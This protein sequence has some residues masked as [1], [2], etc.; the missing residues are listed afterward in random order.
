VALHKKISKSQNGHSNGSSSKKRPYS[1]IS[2]TKTETSRNQSSKSK[3]KALDVG[4]CDEHPDANHTNDTCRTQK[5]RLERA[6]TAQNNPDMFPVT[7][8]VVHNP[9]S[10]CGKP[11]YKGHPCT[12]NTARRGPSSSSSSS[13]RHSHRP[14]Q[15]AEQRRFAAAVMLSDSAPALASSDTSAQR[16]PTRPPVA[17][18]NHRRNRRNTGA[19]PAAQSMPDD[20]AMD[21]DDM[22]ASADMDPDSAAA[23]AK[24]AQR[25][26][27][28]N[29]FSVP[30][31]NKS[32]CIIIPIVLQ[33][34]RTYAMI[35]T[36]ANFS[37]CTPEF[38]AAVA[39]TA[40]TTS[41]TSGQIQLGHTTAVHN[42]IG[43]VNLQL[44]YNKT[45]INHTFEV[46]DIFT[47]INNKNI[48]CCI[49]MDLFHHLNLGLTGL[50]VTH[51]DLNSENTPFPP[52]P[53]DPE[54]E[55]DKVNNSPFGID[56][57][58]TQMMQVLN[59]LFK[60][61]ANIDIPNTYCNLPGAIVSLQ[62]KPGCVAYRKPYPLP[63]AFKDAVAA[64]ILTWLKEN[65][66]EVSTSH[67]GF[68]SNLLVVSKKDT[69]SGVY[70]F[71][72]PR[73]VVDLRNLNS[74]LEVT[75]TQS[76]PLISEIHNKIGNAVVHSVI[77]IKSCF[78]TFLV[79]KD[80]R[81]KLSFT[82]PYTN[83]QYQFVKVPFGINFMGNLV[84]RVLQQLF[85][86][87]PSVTVYVD[88][89]SISTVGD[90]ATHTDC[91]A[92]V[93]RRLT[94][95]NLVISAEKVVLAQTTISILGWVISDGALIPDYRKV[96]TASAFKVPTTATQLNSFLGYMN[97]F[98]GSIPLF[99]HISAPL[100]KLR[101]VSNL[102]ECWTDLHTRAFDKL[103]NALVSAPLIFP[104]D[105]HYPLVVATDASNT[106]ISGVLYFVK[107]NRMHIVALASR[108]LSSTE[109]AYSTTRREILAIVYCFQRF[110][111][112]LVNRHF[113]LHTD[114]RSLIYLHSQEVPNHL[115][116]T[117]Y[118]TLFS[119]DYT[120]VH[121]P[122]HL[123]YIADAGSRLFSNDYNYNLVGGE[124]VDENTS[125]FITKRKRRENIKS[126]NNADA[127]S[128]TQSPDESP[129]PI[130][131]TKKF[132][133]NKKAKPQLNISSSFY[134]KAMK[135]YTK[136]YT[137]HFNKHEHS[138]TNDSTQSLTTHPNNIP[139]VNCALQYA[140][141]ITPPSKERMDI[142][143]KAHLLGHFG[144]KAVEDTIHKDYKMHWTNMRDDIT[145]IISNCDA[146]SHHNISK[147]GYHPFRSVQ[148]DQ[149]L[150]HWSMDLGTFDITSASGNNFMLVMVE[151]FSRFTILRALPDKTA[152]SV[153]KELLN[154]FCLFGFPKI[155]TSDL[156]SE[157]V[158]S[159]V[160]QLIILS[161]ID[162]RLSLPY[163]PLGN[164]VTERYV[165]TAKMGIV[166]MLKGKYDDWDLYLNCV[167]L[168]MNFKY[169]KI[170]KSRPYS[171]VFNKQP[172]GFTDYSKVKPTLSTE[173]ADTRLLDER[174]A[175]AQN[176]VIPEIAKLMR[177]TQAKDHEIFKKG[178]RVLTDMYPIG[179]KVMI[180]N[181]D[182]KRKVDER[183]SG[184]FTISG[185]TKNKSYILVDPANNLLSRDV[186][187]HH[188]KLI[189]EDP[190]PLINDDDDQ[191]YE[192]QAILTHRGEHGNYEYLIHWKGY[193]DPKEHTWQT[194]ADFD[195]KYHIELYWSRR[196][197]NKPKNKGLSINN[198][199][200]KKSN[201]NRHSNKNAKV[202]TRSV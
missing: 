20:D 156:G 65:V 57:E 80:D 128:Q 101:N 124:L 13:S 122:G 17:P 8:G 90:L 127:Y 197:A 160:S 163:N 25:C 66:I 46:F 55:K 192:V 164:S 187:T 84:Q 120:I 4:K 114:H 73:V 14:P 56:T 91:V 141:Y 98:R 52:T 142:I 158:N 45:L 186:P 130:K 64:Q 3:G 147:V 62:T 161:G 100:D 151:H 102:T 131:R 26:K 70:S 125:S 30:P 89:I 185:Y 61:N 115:L 181:V 96:N 68:N 53:I 174:L 12:R 136:D 117:Y 41:A 7:S 177:E 42:R 123:N 6:T 169:S 157:F 94:K 21:I 145:K 191:H 139:L 152:L 118:E 93:I 106:G 137:D 54:A 36:G 33:N 107:D 78:N 111:K 188:I 143:N 103:K 39:D 10:F 202:I 138:V 88:D 11:Y 171:I 182:R 38:A 44:F 31:S 126:K 27:Y 40:P 28:H 162:R 135:D 48:P 200:R 34:I 196:N 183:F 35:D 71:A 104:V 83:R 82:C 37:M 184:P 51:F 50:I 32:N 74:I 167:Q 170:H 133:V 99:A 113:T 5:R 194:E 193:N 67:N 149:P 153:A 22:L 116:L 81:H 92:E 148:P 150:D 173:K 24:Q 97:Y 23:V 168:A 95:A 198:A 77:D 155:L 178:H 2:A 1:D 43:T 195:S 176:V 119:L 29:V 166:K 132:R 47:S 72:K 199:N 16:K 85:Y 18:S 76:F 189:R 109:T 86:D 201:R 190:Q 9:C 69:S 110:H 58:R 79:N 175:F 63:Y 180:K 134:K 121:L 112:W 154:I 105:Y 159:T 108:S 15:N 144:I 75:D 179:S 146:C 59:P 172:N 49:G 129:I 60:D 87:L 19:R 165:G 140:E